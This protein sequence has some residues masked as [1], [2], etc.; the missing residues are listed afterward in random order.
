VTGRAFPSSEY[1]DAPLEVD[2]EAVE[3]IWPNGLKDER[4]S[5]S[6]GMHRVG[7]AI[8]EGIFSAVRFEEGKVEGLGGAASIIDKVVTF[9]RLG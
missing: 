1:G 3:T 5:G 7:E 6:I 9:T 8:D 4:V 2:V